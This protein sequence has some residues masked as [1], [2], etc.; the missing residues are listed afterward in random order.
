M[1]IGDLSDQ[2]R[3]RKARLFYV[4]VYDQAFGRDARAVILAVDRRRLPTAKL[5]AKKQ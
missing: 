1:V 3:S 4:A 5:V 2:D